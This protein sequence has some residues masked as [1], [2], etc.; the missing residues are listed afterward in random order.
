MNQSELVRF[1]DDLGLDDM[2]EPLIASLRRSVRI[3]PLASPVNDQGSRFGGLPYAPRG[4]EWPISSPRDERHDL[5]AYEKTQYIPGPLRFLCQVNLAELPFTPDALNLPEDGILLFFAAI[6][7]VDYPETDCTGE[8]WSVLYVSSDDGALAS[9][10]PLSSAFVHSLDN[11]TATPTRNGS[12]VLPCRAMAMS[13]FWQIDQDLLIGH[14]ELQLQNGAVSARLE[15]VSKKLGQLWEMPLHLFG[16][17]A[18]NRQSPVLSTAASWRERSLET[19]RFE[20]LLQIDSDDALEM[21]WYGH[22][23]GYFIANLKDEHPYFEETVLVTQ[24]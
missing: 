21:E 22:G 19:S 4:F 23:R 12:I 2:R 15:Q 9:P 6:Q 5:P 18:E 7:K 20:Q 1:V 16:G 24:I 10:P 3:R 8:D 11:D 17:Y 14:P 13:E